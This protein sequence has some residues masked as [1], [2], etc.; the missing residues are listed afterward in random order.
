MQSSVADCGETILF[1]VNE[2]AHK[3]GLGRSKVYEM[4]ESGELP[5]VR[6]GSSVRI[7]CRELFD[8]IRRRLKQ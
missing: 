4:A 1:R 6:I 8:W 5:V 7:P 2:V 3:L